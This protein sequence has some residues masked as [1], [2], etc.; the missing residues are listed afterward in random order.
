MNWKYRL[1]GITL[2]G[3]TVLAGCSSSDPEGPGVTD[4]GNAADAADAA[5]AADALPG[6]SPDSGACNANPDPCCRDDAS[7]A[8][9][10][11]KLDGGS[12]ADANAPVP[13]ASDPDAT[14][15]AAPAT[16]ADTHG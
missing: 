7:A 5:H 16:D 4:G 2:A 12:D 11:S 15:D 14:P 13:D 8:C 1:L 6:P 3:G 9:I 10:A